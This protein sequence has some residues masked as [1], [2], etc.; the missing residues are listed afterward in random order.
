[1][2]N[3]AEKKRKTNDRRSADIVG[4]FLSLEFVL[5]VVVGVVLVVLRVFDVI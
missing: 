3:P 1:M 5:A 2:K 4:F